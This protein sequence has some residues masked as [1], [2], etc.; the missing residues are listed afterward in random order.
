MSVNAKAMG[1]F[2]GYNEGDGFNTAEL[3]MTKADESKWQDVL[4][5]DSYS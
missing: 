5:E 2:Y 4:D 3:M 1:Q